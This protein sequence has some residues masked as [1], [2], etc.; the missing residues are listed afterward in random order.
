M[1]NPYA[2]RIA[3]SAVG[4]LLAA[5]V[6]SPAGAA[7]DQPADPYTTHAAFWP[8]EGPRSDSPTY[9]QD[10]SGNGHD[11]LVR[12][13]YGWGRDRSNSRDGALSLES[14]V[15]SCAET[16]APA[17][18]TDGSFTAVAWIRLAD[19]GVARTVL[20]QLGADGTGFR[21]EYLSATDRWQFAIPT[22]G[23]DGAARE[24]AAVSQQAPAWDEWTHVAVVHD[25]EARVARLYVDG[26]LQ[27]VTGPVTAQMPANGPTLIGCGGDLSGGRTSPLGGLVDEARFWNYALDPDR[28]AE[29][30]HS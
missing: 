5:V 2:V 13:S 24:V 25:Q 27:S 1:R 22:V 17:V 11:L 29:M 7:A 23:D 26:A 10:W 30:A 28:I 6:A 19:T 16:A 12:G 21:L 14:G 9:L 3:A 4:A 20:A 18:R 8:L 15:T